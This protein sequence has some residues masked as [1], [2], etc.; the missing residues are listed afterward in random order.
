MMLEPP[1]A[2]PS[3]HSRRRQELLRTGQSFGCDHDRHAERRGKEARCD[4]DPCGQPPG[5][6]RFGKLRAERAFDFPVQY[7]PAPGAPCTAQD[8]VELVVLVAHAD[9]IIADGIVRPRG[10]S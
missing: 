1:D 7:L 3:D 4:E 9:D 2:E 6:G 8:F 10:R 5:A